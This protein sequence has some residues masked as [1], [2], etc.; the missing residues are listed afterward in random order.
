MPY[1]ACILTRK[2]HLKVTVTGTMDYDEQADFSALLARL[3]AEYDLHR[4]LLD[5][6]RLRKRLDAL[7]AYRLAES[8]ISAEAAVRGVRLACVPH[9]EDVVFAQ[10]LETS[11]A[12][13]S[14]SYRVFSDLE[15]A[16]AWL[17][18]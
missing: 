14:I 16:E 18:S 3:G 7:D 10:S 5:E 15:E 2:T 13:R 11:M 12:N 4:V 1:T 6:R 9:P 8:T 17:T